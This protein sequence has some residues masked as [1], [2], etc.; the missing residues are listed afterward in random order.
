M[1]FAGMP[2]GMLCTRRCCIAF[3]PGLAALT[4]VDRC[5]SLGLFGLLAQLI[6]GSQV[7]FAHTVDKPLERHR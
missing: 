5:G 3:T 4:G 7:T 6:D 1:T 2:A